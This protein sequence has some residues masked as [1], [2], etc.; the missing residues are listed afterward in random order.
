MRRP[1]YAIRVDGSDV[2]DRFAGRAISI[3]IVDAMGTE[4]DTV[5]ITVDDRGRRLPLPR[6]G[7]RMEV[8]IGYAGEG[9]CAPRLYEVDQVRLSGWPQVMTIS[10]KA[11]GGRRAAKVR[12][13]GAHE[14]TTIGAVAAAFARR[15]RL[16][17]RVEEAVAG[18]PIPFE[19]QADES[20][21]AFLT[22]VARER[23]DAQVTVKN[24][25]LIVARPGRG[26]TAGGAAL[27]GATIAGDDRKGATRIRGYEVA[28][29]DQPVH[30]S[31]EVGWYDRETGERRT[32]REEVGDGPV[33]RDRR[34]AGSEAEA[35][36]RADALARQIGRA[37]RTATFECEGDPWLWAETPVTV[38]AVGAGIDGVW[39]ARRVEHQWTDGGATTTVEC[40]PPEP[41]KRA[42]ATAV[43]P[44]GPTG[45]TGATG[46]TGGSG[47]NAGGGSWDMGDGPE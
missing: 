37:G 13:R 2:T 44:A 11:L 41:A 40:E 16:E 9:L 35:K 33:Y 46:A 17:P 21:V 47:S 18:V 31:A 22:R 5:E 24:G 20:D 36:D 12:R 1:A 10:G 45:A 29:A 3:A 38:V 34:T 26:E 42:G 27:P 14:A 32:L 15:M 6:K 4:S 23:A 8:A 39:S 19:A 25:R 43:A 7:A 30:G 28:D